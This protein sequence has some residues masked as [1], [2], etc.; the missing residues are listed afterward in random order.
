MKASKIKINDYE[1]DYLNFY[2]INTDDIEDIVITLKNIVDKNL[3]LCK[4]LNNLCIYIESIIDIRDE[5]PFVSPQRG[6]GE[7]RI[8]T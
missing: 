8:T 7:G 5:L 1:Y 2:R 4:N 6:E 3:N